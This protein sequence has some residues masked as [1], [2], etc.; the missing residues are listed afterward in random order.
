M[1]ILRLKNVIFERFWPFSKFHFSACSTLI[2]TQLSK[3]KTIYNL[4]TRLFGIL[5]SVF[6]FRCVPRPG[7]NMERANY[8]TF[9]HE[10]VCYTSS[11]ASSDG[12]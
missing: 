4:I 11:S 5:Q 8:G 9:K 2:M 7:H 3:K 1:I 6:H 12:S 10:E